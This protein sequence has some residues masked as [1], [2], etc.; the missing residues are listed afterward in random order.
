MDAKRQRR[1]IRSSIHQIGETYPGIII[2]NGLMIR[3]PMKPINMT[4]DAQSFEVLMNHKPRHDT[5]R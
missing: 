1:V 2:F 4:L 3:G 5:Q